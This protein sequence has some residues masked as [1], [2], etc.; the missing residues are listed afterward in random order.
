MKSSF[1]PSMLRLISF[2]GFL[3]MSSH[4]EV[5]LDL[6]ALGKSL[7]GWDS[8]GK[9]A[10]NYE[11]SGSTYRSYMPEIT[12]TPEGGIF[13]SVR[14]DY[15]RGIF[16]SN[17]FATLEMTFSA[18]GTMSSTQSSIAIQG[19][20][21]TSD[22]MRSGAKLGENKG[23]VGMAVKL[24]GDMVANLTEK[25]S[26]ENLVEAGRVTF[27]AAV[28]HNYNKVFQAVSVAKPVQAPLK[29]EKAPAKPG[30][31]FEEKK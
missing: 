17:D 11:L 8:K 24:G 3:C 14:I 16:A 25:L 10:A 31:G 27:P 29:P 23:A 7:G 15:V 12:P 13:I 30:S 4:A 28:R 26:R 22:V 18:D 2:A 20:T 5:V 6:D 9:R 1:Y 19:K 21:I